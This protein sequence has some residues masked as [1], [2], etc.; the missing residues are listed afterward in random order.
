[1]RKIVLFILTAA[2]LMPAVSFAGGVNRLGGVGPRAGGMSGAYIAVSDDVSAFYYN[3]AGLIDLED[4]YLFV[5]SEL[6]IPKF[7]YET[8][9]GA[10]ENSRDGKY[11]LL[12]LA[13]ASKKLSDRITIG[14]GVNVPYGLGASFEEKLADGFLETESLLT[15]TNVSPAVALRLTDRLSLGFSANI[16]YSQFNYLAPFDFQGLEVG[17]A[18]SEADGWGLGASAGLLWR[19]ND[20]FSWG[21]AY[22]TESQ[23]RLEGTTD[24]ETMLAGKFSDD[25]NTR[26]TFPARLGTGIAVRP[27][28]KWLIA[29]DANWFDY[30]GADQ[31]NI[32]Y[33]QLP[34]VQQK[35]NWQN[36]Y[37]LHLGTEYL[38]GKRW[39]LRTGIAYQ[40]AA[41]PDSTVSPLTPDVTGWDVSAGLGY[42]WKNFSIDASY[43]YAW[44]DRTVGIA[45][46]HIAPGRYEADVHT[47]ALGLTY[48]F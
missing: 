16:G 36:N 4:N 41:I 23:V 21:L 5:G 11:H 2:V 22:S 12:P 9:L 8:P 39:A 26:F 20:K 25:F 40:T 1:M 44:G 7:S 27:T 42:Y 48:R 45:A 17:M 34:A 14:L 46:D 43:I 24:F 38:L 18:D 32:N 47:L 30:S 10:S 37:A 35:L 13:G 28:D 19:P 31:L 29:F 33:E 3:P 15:L 6:M